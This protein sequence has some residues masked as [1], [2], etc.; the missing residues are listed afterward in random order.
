MDVEA[1]QE[2]S[3][4]VEL[5]QPAHKSTGMSLVCGQAGME[6]PVGK[7]VTS[8]VQYQ[9]NKWKKQGWTYPAE[10]YK[11]I[12]ND[13]D[14]R[15]FVQKLSLDP[16]GGW[17]SL[18]E[19]QKMSMTQDKTG[20][21]GMISLWEVAKLEGL[22]YDPANADS[23]KLLQALVKDL[24]NEPHPKPALAEAGHYVY[25]YEKTLMDK[26][27]KRKTNSLTSSVEH[28]N[29]SLEEFQ[30]AKATMGDVVTTSGF[31][32]AT[33]NSKGKK[34]KA[35]KDSDPE[36]K[37]KQALKKELEVRNDPDMTMTITS[38]LWLSVSFCFVSVISVIFKIT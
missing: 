6:G 4:E 38:C 25:K 8:A 22:I 11:S 28:N 15:T 9:L 29:L 3:V 14:R 26:T 36:A 27:S 16:E 7:S 18:K 12:K 33:H 37:A 31:G 30:D 23:M 13:R 21:S 10:E 24:E 5:V 2:D 34:P 1:S 19:R 35:I 20:L 17:L 32:S